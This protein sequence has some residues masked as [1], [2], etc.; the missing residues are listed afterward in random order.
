MRELNL[1][2]FQES[3]RISSRGYAIFS[4]DGQFQPYDFTR[5]PVGE[6]DVLVEILYAGI[7]HSDI[8]TVRGE[9]GEREYPI[10]P[11][12][13]IAGEVI[14]V[15]K[16]VSKFAIGDWIGIGCM[17]NACQQCPTCL[18]HEEQF[19]DQTV[20][21]YASED[22]FHDREYTQGGYSNNIVVHE[23]FGIKIPKS[24]DLSRVAPLL[25]A[26]ITTYSPLYRAGI[27][28][29]DKVGIV[30]LG[31]LGHMAVQYAASFGARVSV[32]ATSESKRELAMELGAKEFINVKNQDEMQKVRKDFDVILSTVPASYE[33]SKYLGL[34][35][36]KGEMIVVGLPSHQDPALLDANGLIWNFSRKLYSSLIGGIKE[37]QEMLDY[38]IEHGIY[39]MVEM[40]GGSEIDW[41][42]ERV[43][44]SDVKFRFVIDMKSLGV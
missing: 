30:G 2:E 26:G 16:S 3:K 5:H 15:G 29:G 32:F 18:D 13:E 8:H 27:K 12:H 34:L 7:C 21:T 19:C 33:I 36:P 4:K 23:N 14:A 22:V 9:W 24:A 10:V 40:I 17:V 38:S 43:L 28:Q 39:P 41:A 31:G 11:G 37:T 42:Y 20:W 44:K 25:C 6:H 35:K 1:K